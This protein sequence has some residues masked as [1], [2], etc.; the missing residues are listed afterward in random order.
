MAATRQSLYGYIQHSRR[1]QLVILTQ[2]F[3]RFVVGDQR[4]DQAVGPKLVAASAL[5]RLP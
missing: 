2:N 1:D 4:R 5:G 3:L